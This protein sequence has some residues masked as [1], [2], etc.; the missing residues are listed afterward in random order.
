MANVFVCVLLLCW[1]QTTYCD[2]DSSTQELTTHTAIVNITY[3]DANG[4][5]NTQ[6][7]DDGHFGHK[8]K[9]EA[10]SGVVVL[11]CTKE[12]KTD[13]CTDLINYTVT[14]LIVLNYADN[15]CLSY[16]TGVIHSV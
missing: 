13:G 12:N 3:A 7:L 4:K 6:Q 16:G 9:V 1:I 8:S 14:L 2:H 11:V 5:R 15:E 10:K